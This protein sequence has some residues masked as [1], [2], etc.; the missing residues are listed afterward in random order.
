VEPLAG[1][2]GVAVVGGRERRL[3]FEQ[4]GLRRALQ[5]QVSQYVRRLGQEQS[6]DFD[7][8][9]AGEGGAVVFEQRSSALGPALGPHRDTGRAQGVHVAINR[10]LRHFEAPGQLA[11][12]EPGV[13]LEQQQD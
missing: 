12:G 1:E 10:P 11:G 2:P 5:S 6:L 7:G 8:V 4:G 9:Q 13:G 3:Q